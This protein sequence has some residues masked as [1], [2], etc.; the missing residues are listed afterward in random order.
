MRT[1]RSVPP[2]AATGASGSVVANS[3]GA[4]S[5]PPEAS[6]LR[7]AVATRAAVLGWAAACAALAPPYDTSNDLL[8][9]G[10]LTAVDAW[11]E[12]AL[13]HTANWDGA[14][15]A[16]IAARG[17][18]SEKELAF[19]PGLPACLAVLRCAHLTAGSRV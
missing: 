1:R 12:R 4:R 15:F 10:P 17:Y 13:G 6:V 16:R 18:T 7:V 11:V 5:Q 14:Y 9:D 2:I 3:S 8:T 19:F